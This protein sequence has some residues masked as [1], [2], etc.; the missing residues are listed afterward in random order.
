MFAETIAEKETKIVE[1]MAS[2]SRLR[3]KLT[4]IHE[5]TQFDTMVPEWQRLQNI[6]ATAASALGEPD[7]S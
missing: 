4:A 6:A 7:V 3:E 5:I 1:L 2:V